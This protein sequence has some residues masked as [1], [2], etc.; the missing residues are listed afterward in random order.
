MGEL[1][2]RTGKPA[3]RRRHVPAAIF[4]AGITLLIVGIA[5]PQTTLHL[6]RH[7]GTVILAFDVSSSMEAKDIKPSRVKA[8]QQA[9]RAFVRNQPHS[10]RIGVVAFSNSGF[11]LQKPTTNTH[12][13]LSAIGRLNP[14]GGTSLGDAIITSLRAVAGKPLA[15]DADALQ[16]GTRQPSL[17]FLGSAVVIL[18]SDGENTAQLDPVAAADVAS[19]AGV[20]IDPIGL[21]SASG[22]VV[23]VDGF[24][25]TTNL[26]EGLL[27]RIAKTSNGT[28]YHASEASKLTS[29][30]SN[31]DL[32]LTVQGKKTEVT[33]LFAAGALVLFLVAAA[34][35]I[36]WF[37]R[38]V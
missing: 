38:V 1:R 4:L 23:N 20:R 10:I 29:V 13:V 2:T 15:L 16:N 25:V 32:K 34:L 7:E 33:S 6:P 35:S 26:D 31:I 5:R 8:A 3:G 19:Q 27:R 30:Y 24:S 14:G 36:R 28:Y 12:D 18:L 22:A 17:P 9:A 21:G 11:V 37:G